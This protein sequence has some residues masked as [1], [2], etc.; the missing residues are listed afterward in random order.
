M[1]AE[2]NSLEKWNAFARGGIASTLPPHYFH[3]ICRLE[4]QTFDSGAC[5]V[6]FLDFSE[7]RNVKEIFGEVLCSSTSIKVYIQIDLMTTDTTTG[8]TGGVL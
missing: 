4:L 7:N 1:R 2:S 6:H 5:L 3:Q 8:M